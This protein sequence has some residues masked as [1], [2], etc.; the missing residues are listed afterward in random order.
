MISA[1]LISQFLVLAEELHFGR[2]ALR[3]HMSQPPLSQAINRLEQI[4][5]VRLFDRTNKAVTLTDAGRVF[6]EEARRLQEQQERAI[7]HTRQA[8]K[9]F[10]G[11]LSMG[12]VGSVSYGLLPELLS[13][14]HTQ[15][16]DVGIDLREL[17]SA[18]QIQE[19]NS[20]RI[21]LGIVRI[22]LYG[23][24]DLDFTVIARE[25][26]VAVLPRDHPLARQPSISLVSLA[27]EQFMMFPPHKV[28]SL[29]AK[30][31]MAC[32]AAGF[33]PKI[34]LESWQMPTMVSLVN[35]GMGVALLPS[36]IQSVSHPGVAY[37]AIKD[38]CEHLDLEIAVAVRKDNTSRL[39]RV[40]IESL[41]ELDL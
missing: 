14:F 36:Q 27:D 37:C 26:M 38:E 20:R 33:S 11:T 17:T 6:R 41:T 12:F 32:H 10:S 25:R 16:P 40:L 29:H 35:A 22:P 18:E 30:T 31:V 8:A 34:S 21:D 23:A 19:L 4:L 1:R 39:T 2:A 15:Y 28:A 5:D 3:L 24:A 9:G 13:Q 7:L